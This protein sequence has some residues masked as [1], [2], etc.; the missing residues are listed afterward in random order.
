LTLFV[1]TTIW[2]HF[3]RR[4][5]QP[6]SPEIRALRQTLLEGG[7]VATGFVLQEVLQGVSGPRAKDQ[8][9]ERFRTILLLVPSFTHFVEAAELR[10]HC[11]R[12]GIQVGTV[13]ALIAQLCIAN[14]LTLLSADEDFTYMARES[15]LRVWRA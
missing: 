15:R 12:S 6:N 14:D 13:D 2:S 4:D 5:V 3:F 10:N 7:V 11:R 1:D 8:I 9:V